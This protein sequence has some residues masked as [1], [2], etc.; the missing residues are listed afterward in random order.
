M[1]RNNVEHHMNIPAETRIPK[2]IHYC[3]FGKNPKTKLVKI[4][5]KSWKKYLPNYKIRE[6]NDKDIKKCNN[7]Y[8]QEAYRAKKWAFITDYF[9]LYALYNYGGIY[10]DSDNEV[11][12]SFDDFLDLKF[13][14]GYENYNGVVSPFTAVLGAEKGNKIIKELLD[15]YNNLHFINSDGSH[16]LYTNTARVTDYFKNKYNFVPPYDATDKKYLE[17]KSIIFPATTFCNYQENV[18]Y[19]VH[20]F[21][22]S[23]LPENTKNETD[24][25]KFS[26]KDIFS[27]YN[28]NGHKVWNVLGI[29]FKF[30]RK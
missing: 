28:Q 24:K 9:R 27:V 1:S 16:N 22:G 13:F 26:L 30:K 15:D 10:L 11:F 4:C 2:L 3:W 12:K 21:S 29:K 14:S 7:T 23:W 25:H 8:V 17:D 19:A 18:S 5:I 20:H 6:W